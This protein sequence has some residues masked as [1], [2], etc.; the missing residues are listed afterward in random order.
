MKYQKQLLMNIDSGRPSHFWWG[1][2]N[3]EEQGQCDLPHGSHCPIRQPARHLSVNQRPWHQRGTWPGQGD[4]GTSILCAL[5]IG[6]CSLPP[7][8][9]D[10]QG[11]NHD[12]FMLKDNVSYCQCMNEDIWHD[13]KKS[14]P[15][16]RKFTHQRPFRWRRSWTCAM[17]H[18]WIRQRS[19][20]IGMTYLD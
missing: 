20:F 17:L 3:T 1:Q 19:D 7:S 14:P 18:R 16:G 2:G 11:G 8:R 4:N 6:L 5:L 9:W 13:M 10:Y 15:T 12:F